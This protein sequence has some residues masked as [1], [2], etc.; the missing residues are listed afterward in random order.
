MVEFERNFGAF[1][2]EHMLAAIVQ[3]FEQAIQPP[4]S[5]WKNQEACLYAIGILTQNGTNVYEGI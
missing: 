5:P 4:N 3:R 1:A 2:M